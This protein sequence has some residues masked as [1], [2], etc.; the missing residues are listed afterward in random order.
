MKFM[1]IGNRPDIF[2]TEEAR[3]SVSSDVPS[4]LIIQINNTT[5]LLHKYPLLPKC[6]LLQQLSSDAGNPSQVPLE[7]HDIPGEDE[8]FE[9]C[10]K[11]CY[12]ITINLSAHNFVPAFCA[13]NFLGMTESVEKG[14]FVLKLEI[15]FKSCILEG[16]KDSIVTL[17]TTEKL[18]EWSENLGLIR[19]CINSIVEKILMQPS[20]V[21]WSYT[22]TRPGYT[23]KHHHSAPKDW[24]TEDISNLDIDLFRTII[25]AIRSTKLLSPQLIGE[26]LHVYACRWLPDTPQSS[27]PETSVSQTE[28]AVE[29]HK[30]ILETIVNLIPSDRGSVSFGF[31]LRLLSKG[32]IL[33]VSTSTKTQLI[34]RCGQQLMEATVKDLLFPSHSS[35]DRH[36]YETDLVLTVLESFLVLWRRQ[37][38]P[39]DGE[40]LRVIRKVAQLIDSYLQVVARDVNMPALKIVTLAESL[41]EIAR[42]KHDDLYRAINIYL[43]EHPDLSKAEKKRLCRI[44]DCRKLS[45]EVCAHA[46]RNERLPLR[47]VVQVLYY[48]QE[49]G[50]GPTPR[51]PPPDENPEGEHP[52]SV[53]RGDNHGKSGLEEQI[54]G[55][56]NVGKPTSPNLVER[57][58]RRTIKSD[59]RQQ[60]ESE[61]KVGMGKVR[62]TGEE[63]MSGSLSEPNKTK[64]R[65]SK[66]D[67]SHKRGG[68]R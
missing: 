8:A 23:G 61:R 21:T 35:S 13:A 14:N 7:L 20:K 16:W 44:L 6:G 68:N 40:S 12:G 22:Y 28:S 32:K 30:Q 55:V 9:L 10:A 29:K 37:A 47:T 54:G 51:N 38:S 62:E 63:G 2:Y 58:H 36:F 25:S 33:G 67:L 24:W 45:P 11:F 39:E 53:T 65:I 3:R 46:I 59:G 1:K 27:A 56:E 48:E 5:Y 26:A 50:A 66:S 64:E 4:D 52:Q 31:L 42:P 49:R 17:Q 60:L 19:H 41:P 57:V 15:F 43:K 18:F 34:R